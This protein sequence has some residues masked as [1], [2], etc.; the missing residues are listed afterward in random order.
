MKFAC[1][2]SQKRESLKW[3]N[4]ATVASSGGG[5]VGLA[6][7]PCG[8]VSDLVAEGASGCCARAGSV[9]AAIVKSRAALTRAARRI[10]AALR[11]EPVPELAWHEVASRALAE[12]NFNFIDTR[13]NRAKS[14]L[15]FL[16]SG[17][18]CF[19]RQCRHARDP[20]L[21]LKNGCAKDDGLSEISECKIGKLH[22][23]PLFLPSI[24]FCS[25]VRSADDFFERPSY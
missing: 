24:P 18:V 2:E 19:R 17:A 15:D 4:M 3:R 9:Q 21:R 11:L 25:G 22:R 5:S 23:Y 8:A 1:P 7:S 13:W 14:L 20:S 10:P 6:A 16:G 12:I